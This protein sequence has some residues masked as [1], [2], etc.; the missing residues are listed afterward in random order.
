MG[1]AYSI[2]YFTVYVPTCCVDQ[3]IDRWGWRFNEYPDRSR[4]YYQAVSTSEALG[5]TAFEFYVE[6]WSCDKMFQDVYEISNQLKCRVLTTCSAGPD[7]KSKLIL[8]GANGMA[9]YDPET[10]TCNIDVEMCCPAFSLADVMS[11][12]FDISDWAEDQPMPISESGPATSF[13]PNQRLMQNQANNE[14]KIKE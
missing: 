7:M 3:I 12:T 5:L 11:S 14:Q 1:W 9:F 8:P 4:A 6:R 10:E 13:V 2:L